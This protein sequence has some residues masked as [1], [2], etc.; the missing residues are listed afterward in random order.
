VGSG[1]S[2]YVTDV[3]YV[4][5][6]EH[7]LSP[8]RLRLAAALNGFPTP[9]AEDFDYCE[10]GSGQGDTL[11][12]LAAANP[13]ARFLGVDINPE[14]VA[15]AN[16]LASEAGLTN[17]RFLE[18]DFEQLGE[19]SLPDLD[20]ISAHGVLSWIGPAK[21]KAL[22][23]FAS[24]KLKA[25]GLLYVGYN[26][27]PGWAAVEPLRQ[28]LL[29]GATGALGDSLE[30]ARRGLAFAKQMHDAGAE[31]FKD[32]PSAREMLAT[33]ERAGLSYV[34]HEY[35]NAHWAPMYFAQ[36]A[37]EM[38]ASDLYFTGQLPLYLNYRDLAIPQSLGK[39]FERVAD[40][41]TFESLKDFALNEFFRRD[42]YIK[43]K[44]TRSAATTQA[45]FD[46][47]PFGLAE[48]VLPAQRDVTLPHHT[49]RFE[50]AL[51]DALF[52]ALA[53]GATTAESLAARPDLETFGAE[54]VR[55]ALLRA[56]LG[57][58]VVPMLRTTNAKD[59]GAGRLRIPAAYNRMVL[60]GSLTTGSPIVLASPVT[61]TATSLPVLR[62]IAI[63]LL[64]EAPATKHRRWIRDHFGRHS[65]RLTVGGRLIE[66]GEELE[67]LILD[68]VEQFQTSHLAKFVELGILE[69]HA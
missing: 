58:H 8:S 34:V 46:T 2:E 29:S 7:E 11:V 33:M 3:A 55:A 20:F 37:W 56:V 59:K 21:R 60:R 38:A 48:G 35:L 51:F 22:L 6:F 39:L 41:P 62:A 52:A 23:D 53:E 27:M 49:L 32:N 45:Y 15:F 25:G 18:R 28:L 16:R 40:R 44:A 43:G 31:Y 17:V 14:H 50:G 67:Q 68:E 47:T 26:A 54:Q 5:S 19:E 12:A 1:T 61:G 24:A 66:R 63:R 36:V 57:G 65:L 42:V 4:R 30:R 13:R 10:L 9:P 69:R 64:T